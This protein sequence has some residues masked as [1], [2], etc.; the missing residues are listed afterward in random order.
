[1]TTT[2][3]LSRGLDQGLP[4]RWRLHHHAHVWLVSI[5]MPQALPDHFMIVGD[6]ILRVFMVGLAPASFVFQWDSWFESSRGG[7]RRPD[8]A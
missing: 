5:N 4:G 3:G 7:A 2:S 8:F 6:E 1:M